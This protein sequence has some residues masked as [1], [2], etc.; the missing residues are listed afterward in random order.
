[1]SGYYVAR[2]GST[3]D[4]D[5]VCFDCG[6][7]AG[8]LRKD[9]VPSAAHGHADCLSVIVTLGGRPVLVDPGFFCYNGD[10]QWEVHFR[11]TAAHNTLTVDGRDQAQHISKM[12][13]ARTYTAIPEGWSAAGNL[14]WARGSHDGFARTD[15]LSHHRT[16]WLRP[17]GY[18]V[19]YDEILGVGEHTIQ[20]NFQFAPGTLTREGN[21]VLY[22]ERFELAWISTATPR[23][24]VRC[25]EATPDGGWVAQSLGVREPAPRLTLEL[26]F[27]APRVGLLTVLA[28]R[29]R[30]AGIGKRIETLADAAGALGARIR[31]TGASDEV[32]AANGARV[33]PRGIE[34]DA[35][36]AAVRVRDGRVTG[37]AQAGGTRVRVFGMSHSKG[38]GEQTRAGLAIIN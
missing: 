23:A 25:G 36:L 2:S 30:V 33:L 21:T 29:A 12:A 15:G 26:P 28:D 6:S 38:S 9:D 22:E 19:L 11:K 7:Q 4:A 14:A 10:P 32:F 27:T 5:Y 1:V 13:W 31:L 37:A 17:D 20:A 8:G 34:T 18:V 3:R 35:P 16:V 24:T